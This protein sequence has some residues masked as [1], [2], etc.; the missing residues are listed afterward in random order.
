MCDL[1]DDDLLFNTVD[2]CPSWNLIQPTKRSNPPPPTKTILFLNTSY[3]H[4]HLRL[5]PSKVNAF[6]FFWSKQSCPVFFS[7]HCPG[8]LHSHSLCVILLSFLIL[9]LFAAHHLFYHLPSFYFFSRIFVHPIRPLSLP[10][11]L[12]TSLHFFSLLS[13]SLFARTLVSIV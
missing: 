10:S 4:S 13:L 6:L 5:H 9:Y 3:P 2:H 7:T 11:L 1:A 12:F 8:F